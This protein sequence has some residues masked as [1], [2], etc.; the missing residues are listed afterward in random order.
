MNTFVKMLQ[1]KP[2]NLLN[3]SIEVFHDKLL[4]WITQL[5]CYSVK[6]SLD[7]LPWNIHC[8]S[9][10]R[11]PPLKCYMVNLQLNTHTSI[12]MLHTNSLS[13]IHPS[14]CYPVLLSNTFIETL[15]CRSSSWMGGAT[16]A[17][18][19]KNANDNIVRASLHI[20]N[21]STVRCR[22]ISRG[23]IP[24]QTSTAIVLPND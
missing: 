2:L 10:S 15:H 1:R 23:P 12:E 6:L 11:I 13:Y 5:E 14:K 18:V 3:T 24:C 4:N 17:V 21:A 7:K 19:Q 8:K 9:L 22:K 20:M 16:N